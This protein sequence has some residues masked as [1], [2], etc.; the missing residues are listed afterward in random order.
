MA[1]SKT[2]LIALG[3]SIICPQPGKI[4]T[5]FLK[6][7]KKL[8][9]KLTKK[10][11]RFIIVA[12]G[13]K[14][15]RLYQRAAA[16]IVKLPYEDVDWLGIHATRLNAHLLR[17][18][19]RQSAY[20]TVLDEPKKP[21]KSNWK[22]L[23]AAGWKPG[24]STDYIAVLLAKRFKVKKIIDAG[25]IPFVYSKDFLKYKN[26]SPIKKISWENYQKLIGSKWIPGLPA[27]IDPIAAK[28]ARKLKIPALIVKGTGLKN[29]EKVILGQKFKGT[30]IE[31]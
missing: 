13:G 9:L 27:P 18:I 26:V 20:P 28:L 7:F 16:Q 24:W 5:V 21:V 12:G 29:L 8:I 1:N 31:S 23:I 30:I 17:T 3:G 19:F 22:V 2:T 11:Y 4:N 14:I 15:C 10:G 6:R 25:N